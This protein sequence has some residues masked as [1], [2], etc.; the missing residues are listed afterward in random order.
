MDKPAAAQAIGPVASG[1]PA[2]RKTPFSEDRPLWKTFIAF[3][4]PMLLSN[5]LQSL[6]GTLN[7]VYVGQML[8]VGALAA[9]SSYR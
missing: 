3:L 7:N 2:R 1:A 4:G 6:S 8:G 5:I 9:R